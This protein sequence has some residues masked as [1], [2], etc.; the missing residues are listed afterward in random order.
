M[1]TRILVFHS[2]KLVVIQ[3]SFYIETMYIIHM[4]MPLKRLLY[5]I[6]TLQILIILKVITISYWLF[7]SEVLLFYKPSIRLHQV[8]PISTKG[9]EWGHEKKKESHT[10]SKKQNKKKTGKS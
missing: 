10:G 7:K 4:H 5:K 9:K 6:S 2:L 8:P 1:S 3:K